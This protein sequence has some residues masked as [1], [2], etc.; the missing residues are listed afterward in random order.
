MQINFSKRFLKDLKHL[1]KKHSLVR[2]DVDDLIARLQ[3][4]EI[5]GDRLQGT[6]DYTVY[7]VRLKMSGS[8][9]GK[10]AGYRVIYWLQSVSGAVLLTIYATG[11]Q[12]DISS[13]EINMIISD[14]AVSND[15]DAD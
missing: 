10:S 9:K 1:N 7:K 4:N 15:P 11:E 8:V 13:E 3:A 6:G 14:L 2:R 5:P 12:A